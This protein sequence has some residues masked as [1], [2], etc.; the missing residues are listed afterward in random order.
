MRPQPCVR[1]IR[2]GVLLVEYPDASEEQANR[3]AVALGRRLRG[4]G[5]RGLLD[6]IAG[7]RTLLVLFEPARLRR[8]RLAER[9][10]IESRRGAEEGR[11]RRLIRIPV[12]YGGDDLPELSRASGLSRDEFA[13]RHAAAE[14]RVAFVGFVPGFPYLVGLPPEL[15]APRLASPRRRVAA[16]SVAIGG[17]YTGIYPQD[18]P[19]GWRLIGKTA[20]ELFDPGA[21]P[22]ALLGAGDYVR[23]DPV[24]AE[25][26]AGAPKKPRPVKPPGG[27]PIFRVLAS[28]L[29][30]SIQGAPRYGLGSSGVPPGG[31]MDRRSQAR[32]NALVGNSAIAPVLEMTLVGAELEAL[33]ETVVAVA[34]ADLSADC[35]GRR[36][37][38]GEAFRVTAGERLR[39]GRARRGARAYLAVRGEI[40]NPRLPGETSRRLEAGELVY[41]AV[42]VRRRAI[43]PPSAPPPDLPEELF[44]RVAL[45]PQTTHFPQA[46]IDRFLSSPWRVSSASDRRGL[47]LEGERLTHALAPET[48]PEGT[49]DGSVQVPGNGLPIVLG[50]DGPVTGGYP[51][52]ATVIGADLPLLGQAGPGTTLRFRPV[53]LPEALEAWP[54]EGGRR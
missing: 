52:I 38:C 44:L 36:A 5:V 32:A 2:G 37:P 14:Y 7:A 43:G 11:A 33:E 21:N 47:R 17:S 50:P 4:D 49:V 46:E 12:S 18:S 40:A 39:L 23:F 25:E 27:R 1:D 48:E 35:G 31:A 8:D 34:G 13:R 53:E 9:I 6:A 24:R 51:K 54:A 42:G 20:A 15:C 16:G 22:P 29:F 45:G 41:G 28:G 10:E 19:G 26:L 3:A 30:T